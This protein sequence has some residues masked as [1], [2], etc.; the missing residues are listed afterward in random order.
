M[1]E[2]WMFCKVDCENKNCKYNALSSRV[3]YLKEN[4][5]NTYFKPIKDC[6]HYSPSYKF[7]VTYESDAGNTDHGWVITIIASNEKSAEEIAFNIH[8]KGNLWNYMA[9]KVFQ[10]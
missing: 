3:N 9:I 10:F 4:G 8:K 2:D 7:D 6:E 5:I 1:I